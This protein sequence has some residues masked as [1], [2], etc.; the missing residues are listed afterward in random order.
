MS[1]G[2]LGSGTR[3][4]AG[5]GS[6]RKCNIKIW[7]ANLSLF[8]PKDAGSSRVRGV[9]LPV[10]PQHVAGGRD[11]TVGQLEGDVALEGGHADK[12]QR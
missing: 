5:G 6:M 3:R 9:A 11:G 8:L 1:E 7:A 4:G 2:Q 10:H 12:D